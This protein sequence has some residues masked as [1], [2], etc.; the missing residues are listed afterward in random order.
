MENEATLVAE[1]A[2]TAWNDNAVAAVA[3]QVVMTAAVLAAT[4]YLAR[5]WT[6]RSIRKSQLESVETN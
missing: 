1:S 6:K 4:T 2:A 3:L 5:Q